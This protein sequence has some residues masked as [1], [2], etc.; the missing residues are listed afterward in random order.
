MRSPSLIESKSS[1]N[2]LRR[3]P[4]LLGADDPPHRRARTS[5]DSYSASLSRNPLST[6]RSRRSSPPSQNPSIS[7]IAVVVIS[8]IG[9]ICRQQ[10]NNLTRNRWVISNA[11]LPLP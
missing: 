11:A 10:D 6:N 2:L 1:P 5:T 7:F 3:S 8:S 4:D 9:T